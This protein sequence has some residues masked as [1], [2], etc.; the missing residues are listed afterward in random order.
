[1]WAV[2]SLEIPRYPD[3]PDRTLVLHWDGKSWKRVPSPSPTDTGG[4][5]EDELRGVSAVS[6][7]NVWAVGTYFHRGDGHPVRRR[8]SYATLVLHWNGKVW[9]QVPSPNPSGIGRLNT[10]D[11]VAARS[12]RDVW[13][14][15]AYAGRTGGY[16]LLAEHWQGNSWQTVRMPLPPTPAQDVPE[17]TSIAPLSAGDVWASGSYLDGDFLVAQP[18]V[19]HWNGSAWTLVPTPK[20]GIDSWL[21]GIA[22]VSANDVWAV[23][24]W[25]S[26]E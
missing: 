2:G 16:R 21:P 8:H 22:A 13:A 4:R 17:L 18:L 7:R 23:G 20:V 14:M 15:G 5:H 19:A 26:C 10:L 25:D 3:F 24:A 12:A 6:P 1:A 11:S 9:T